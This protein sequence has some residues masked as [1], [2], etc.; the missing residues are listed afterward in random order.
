MGDFSIWHLIIIAVIVL[1]LFGPNRLPRLGKSLGEAI[2]GFKQG[3]NEGEIDV[4]TTSRR[5]QI[6][7]SDQQTVSSERQANSQ[8]QTE[9]NKNKV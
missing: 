6:Q 1:L 9:Q 7:P 8:Q 3:L 2:R 5:E 4:T